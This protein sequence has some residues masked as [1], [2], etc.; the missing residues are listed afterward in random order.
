METYFIV[1]RKDC[2]SSTSGGS[3]Q[4]TV[5]SPGVTVNSDLSYETALASHSE[6]LTT[7]PS[8]S[9]KSASCVH[10]TVSPFETVSSFGTPTGKLDKLNL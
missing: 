1:G 2:I 10:C 6:S 3:T 8:R 5:T 4:A 9:T 7:A